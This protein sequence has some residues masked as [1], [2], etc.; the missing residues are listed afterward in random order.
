MSFNK[1]GEAMGEGATR[2]IAEATATGYRRESAMVSREA[3]PA[4]NALAS[5]VSFLVSP[6]YGQSC[7]CSSI[8][9]HPWRA[10]PSLQLAFWCSFFLLTIFLLAEK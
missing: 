10:F 4:A 9:R 8:L 7:V 3:L 2:S 1:R 6:P 5:S